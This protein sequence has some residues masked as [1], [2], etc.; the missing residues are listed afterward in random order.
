M[1]HETEKLKVSHVKISNI[2]GIADLEFS[3]LGYTEVVGANGQGKSSVLNAIKAALSGGHDAS[4]LRQGAEKGEIVLVLDDSTQ[5]KKTVTENGTN[6]VVL[7]DEK[8]I[9]RPAEAIR[10][11]HD[12]LSLNPIE[13]LRAPEKD[14][15]DVLLQTMPI[16]V[17]DS[18]LKNIAG[19][20]SNE[21]GKT[22]YGIDRIEAVKKAVF[23]ERTGV[24]RAARDKEGA[25]N[26]LRDTIPKVLPDSPVTDASLLSQIDEIDGERDKEI[27]RISTKLDAIRSISIEK[28]AD[29]RTEIDSAQSDARERIAAIERETAAIVE[30]KRKEI[31]D[32]NDAFAEVNKKA[33]SSKSEARTI[34]ATARAGVQAKLEQI[35]ELQKQHARFEL[36]K[37][38]IARMNS[39]LHELKVE[40]RQYTEALENLDAYKAE[41][42]ESL[43]IPGLEIADGKLL[44][45]GIPFDRLNAAQQVEI[46][47]EIAKLRAGEL[48]LICVD[49]LELLDNEHYMALC[50]SAAESGLQMIVSRVGD[51]ELSI[52]SA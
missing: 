42:L 41:L 23:D 2:L 1:K 7:R 36:T 37:Q 15:I 25:I 6:V 9:Q 44:R 50:A 5:I 19:G 43:P 13:F 29:L 27:Q 46:A 26:Q 20:L 45:Y 35:E 12:V 14:R 8:K 24:N 3:P 11:L 34:H 40:S 17:D 30:D 47:I 48:G 38:N 22:L 21:S 16:H 49:G 28:V 10:A 52:R 18:R 51:G 39:E 31:Q 32:E 33:E 4:L